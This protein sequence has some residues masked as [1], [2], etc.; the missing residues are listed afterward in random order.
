M[1][2]NAPQAKEYRVKR[3]TVYAAGLLGILQ[4]HAELV[5]VLPEDAKIPHLQEAPSYLIHYDRLRC[6][7]ILVESQSFEPIKEGALIPQEDLVFRLKQWM[8]TH[9]CG[10]EHNH[11]TQQACEVCKRGRGD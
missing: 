2:D 8:C 10:Y 7:D 3:Y 9:G 4:G 1:D 11:P 6:F 5:T